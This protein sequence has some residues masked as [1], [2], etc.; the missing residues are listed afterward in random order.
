VEYR[1]TTPDSGV[2]AFWNSD[3]TSLDM[4]AGKGVGEVD[5]YA[6][7]FQSYCEPSVSHRS[8]FWKTCAALSGL[9][10]E[11]GFLGTKT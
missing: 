11:S 1:S 8:F 6:R 4:S 9:C 10:L 2:N 7:V 5:G 3:V